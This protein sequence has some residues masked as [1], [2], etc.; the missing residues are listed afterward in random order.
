MRSINLKMGQ[1]IPEILDGPARFRQSSLKLSA[2][3]R[4]LL[5]FS[6]TVTCLF[7]VSFHK[8]NRLLKKRAFTLQEHILTMPFIFSR[9]KVTCQ[10]FINKVLI[11]S[12]LA[13]HTTRIIS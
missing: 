7:L 1:R 12:V 8:T 2:F 6:L 10:L 11:P 3:R 9:K 4:K 5:D 13:I